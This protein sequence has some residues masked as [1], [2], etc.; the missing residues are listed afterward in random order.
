VLGIPANFSSKDVDEKSEYASI[1]EGINDWKIPGYRGPHPPVGVHRYEF[2][3]Y[4]LDTTLKLGHKVTNLLL[5]SVSR[6]GF[7]YMSSNLT[8]V[9]IYA[10]KP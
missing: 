6:V 4:A 3:L 5:C 2:K 9:S 8:N 1:Q 7:L 10:I